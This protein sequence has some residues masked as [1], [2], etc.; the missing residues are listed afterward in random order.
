MNDNK[1]IK[2][3]EES[4]KV[5]RNSVLIAQSK[6]YSVVNSAMVQAYWEIGQEI[7][8][9]CGENDRAEYGKRLLEYLSEHLTKEFGRGFTIANLKKY[10][11]ILSNFSN[12][13]DTV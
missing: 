8:K 9:A 2:Q 4:Y 11:T 1:I 13:S 6:V 10:E 3:P 12:S 7:H 5:I